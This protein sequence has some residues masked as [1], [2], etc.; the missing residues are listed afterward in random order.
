[1]TDSEKN[2]YRKISRKVHGAKEM[3]KSHSASNG[4]AANMFDNAAIR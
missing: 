4:G 1:M 2:G 3:P